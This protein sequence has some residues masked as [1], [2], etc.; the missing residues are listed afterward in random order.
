MRAHNTHTCAFQTCGHSWRGGRGQEEEEEEEEEEEGGKEGR[1]HRRK[2]SDMRYYV[3]AKVESTSSL[4]T[5][6]PPLCASITPL[7][8]PS[9]LFGETDNERERFLKEISK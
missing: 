1:R 8:R 5:P 9:S 6:S 3:G 4:D 2:L 7:S